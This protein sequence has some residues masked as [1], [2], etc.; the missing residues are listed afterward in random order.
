M[1]VGGGGDEGLQRWNGSES[2]NE[3]IPNL[4]LLCTA[5]RRERKSL[6]NTPNR[7]AILILGMEIKMSIYDGCKSN[8]YLK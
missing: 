2:Y 3:V 8:F 5:V 7:I 6:N 4:D 1:G